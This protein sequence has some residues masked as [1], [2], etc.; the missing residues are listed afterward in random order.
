M[1][2]SLMH[3]S[4]MLVCVYRA[5]QPHHLAGQLYHE[6]LN[7]QTTKREWD[8]FLENLN[9]LTPSSFSFSSFRL[10]RIYRTNPSYTL[11]SFEGGKRN[12]LFRFPLSAQPCLVAACETRKNGNIMRATRT[13][14]FEE[15]RLLLQM[16]IMLGDA[17]LTLLRHIQFT[18]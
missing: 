17:N 7:K 1:N 16:R 8:S 11:S 18:S 9:Q 10:V 4:L 3:V 2:Y 5:T 6:H 14:T 13:C 15:Q 12:P